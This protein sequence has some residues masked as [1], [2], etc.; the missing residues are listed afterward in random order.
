MW[1]LSARSIL[2]RLSDIATGSLGDIVDVQKDGTF[3]VD[4][5]KAKRRGK[6]H[7]IRRVRQT[8][9]GDIVELHD[10]MVALDKLGKYLG[11]W[12][13]DDCKHMTETEL[14]K[15]MESIVSSRRKAGPAQQTARYARV[16]G[17][18]QETR[19]GTPQSVAG[20]ERR[21]RTRSRRGGASSSRSC[22]SQSSSLQ[23][24]RNNR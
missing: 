7:L 2:H 22:S 9:Y 16:F 8:K 4:L 21:R 11:M 10:P 3:K 24:K 17:G 20:R 12:D 14:L 5:H 18:A 6:F 23:T 1:A 13:N 15:E 19:T